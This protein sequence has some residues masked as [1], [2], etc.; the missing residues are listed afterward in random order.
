MKQLPLKGWL[1]GALLL[2]T[3]CIHEERSRCPAWLTLYFSDVPA[4]VKSMEL[5]CKTKELPYCIDSLFHD[6]WKEPYTLEVPRE[7]LHLA[8][9]GNLSP[10]AQTP[11]GYAIPI[12]QQAD[13]LYCAFARTTPDEDL[14]ALSLSPKKNFSTLT[15][16]LVGLQR[17]VPQTPAEYSFIF[18]GSS[19]GQEHNGNILSGT[20]RYHSPSN[21]C[22]IPRQRTSDL[23]L[24]LMLG[25]DSLHR[26]P[27]GKYL[28]EAGYNPHAPE[29][30]DWQLHLD[31]A[32]LVLTVTPENWQEVDPFYPIL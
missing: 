23:T 12:G 7:E 16:N 31:Y 5:V 2:S 3:S 9:W 17:G 29:L 24:I 19:I 6:D 18:E 32:Q 11:S 22:R 14:V 8:L 27:L 20:F 30:T 25:R 4:E 26:F 28:W 21:V 1:L 15:I 10:W 13:S